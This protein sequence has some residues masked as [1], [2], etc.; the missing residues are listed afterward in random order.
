MTTETERPR[1]SAEKAVWVRFETYDELE[2]LRRPNDTFDDIV[3]RLLRFHKRFRPAGEA[4]V[5][6][7]HLP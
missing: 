3:R 1:R 5:R 2:A 4:E 7:E 6:E